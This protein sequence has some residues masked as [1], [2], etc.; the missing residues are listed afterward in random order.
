MNAQIMVDLDGVHPVCGGRWHR[1]LLHKMP[2][3]GEPITMLC[4]RVEP[5]E[6]G[7]AND[8][9]TT[10]QTCW[11]CDLTYRRREGIP[12]RPDHPALSGEVPARPREGGQR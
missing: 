8:Q 6:Y 5:V 3:P 4:G 2:D 10:V 1:V 11:A 7:A 12:V 9:T